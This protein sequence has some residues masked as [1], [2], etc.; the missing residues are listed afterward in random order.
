[1]FADSSAFNHNKYV[2]QTGS[3][4]TD[5]LSTSEIEERAE[6]TERIERPHRRKMHLIVPQYQVENTVA[7]RSAQAEQMR[8]S[9]SEAT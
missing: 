7:V 6:H 5:C 2:G 1:M 9:A 4:S 8:R 3:H